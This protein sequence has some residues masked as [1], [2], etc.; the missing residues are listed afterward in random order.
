MRGM[1]SRFRFS[2]RFVLLWLMPYVVLAAIIAGYDG[3]YGDWPDIDREKL[4]WRVKRNWLVILTY[5][6]WSAFAVWY[7]VRSRQTSPP[8]PGRESGG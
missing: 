2:M 4:N 8:D 1:R 3:P 5:L 7:F 6:W